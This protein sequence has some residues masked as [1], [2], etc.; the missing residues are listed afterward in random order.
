MLRLFMILLLMANVAN[1]VVTTRQH[2]Q[3]DNFQFTM[4]GETL[5]HGKL[6]YER[7]CAG[8]H[9][10]NGDGKGDA[11]AFLETKPRDFKT[12]VFKFRSSEIG[13][14]PSDADL[15]AILS[16]G[17]PTS[18][19]PSFNRVPEQERFAMIQYIKTFAKNVWDDKS[20]YG[21]PVTGTPLPTDD[22]TDFNKFIARAKKGKVL[23]LEAC[24]ICHGQFGRGDGPSGE[25]IEDDWGYPIKPANLQ[26]RTIK[27]GK[28][29]RDIYT[30]LLVGVNATPMP[31]FKDTY[32]DDE[33]WDISAWVLYLRGVKAG[34]YEQLPVSM[35]SD[36]EYKEMTE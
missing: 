29:V 8:C 35:L 19:M 23:Y 34:L 21:E 5:Q 15:M 27:R 10:L 26:R 9:G 12:G 16:K 3:H 13:T 18:S 30:T 14:L 4:K 36:T 28:S 31:S 6:A 11:S 17:I 33:L 2:A 25:G 7:R 20:N 22:F 24:A 1:A 32:T